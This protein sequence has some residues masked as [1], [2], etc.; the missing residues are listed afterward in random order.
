MG[1]FTNNKTKA[2]NKQ[3]KAQFR[4]D[5]QFRDYQIKENDARFEKAELDTELQQANYDKQAT[6]KDDIKKQEYKYDKKIQNRQYR[7]DK[8]SYK[9]S[10]EDYDKQTELNSLS[11]AIALEAAQRAEQEALIS[12]NFGI[13]DIKNDQK[14][15]TKN[16][17]FDKELVGN[18]KTY[19]KET[20]RINQAEIESKKTF[21]NADDVFN[22]QEIT[23][24]KSFTKESFIEELDKLNF[25]NDKLNDDIDFLEDK[26]GWDVEAAQRTYDKAQV[27]NFNQRIDALIAREKAE[28]TARSAGREGLSA[29]REAMSAIAEYGRTQAKLVDDLVFAKEDKDLSKTSIKRTQTYQSRLKQ[30][31]KR[32]VQADKKI[33]TLTKDRKLEKLD[34][35]S[36]KLTLAL[37]QNLKELGFSSE[38][39]TAQKTKTLDDA[40]I[41]IKKLRTKEKFDNLRFEDDKSKIKTTYD[42]AEA[43][44]VADKDKIKLDE[45]AANMAAQGKIPAKPKKPIALPKPLKTPRTQL[46][47]PF[48]PSSPPKPVKG[49]MGKTSVWNDIGDVANMGL[50]VASLFL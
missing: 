30:I 9:Q 46:A 33:T 14:R 39:S 5:R 20:D 26:S 37:N 10:L 22:Q 48:S 34:I 17:K 19:A 1:L 27:P 18:T 44:L 15:N 21:A 45:Y 38:R 42:S 49:A 25:T 40:K 3:V 4:Y 6:Y 43:Q 31:D 29:E 35:N 16:I 2:A 36:S 8:K 28:G 47:M 23:E 24:E 32:I 41:Q 12:K 11:G 13:Q 7:L 50:Q